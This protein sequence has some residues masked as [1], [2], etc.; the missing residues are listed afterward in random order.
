MKKKDKKRGILWSLRVLSSAKLWERVHRNITWL[1]LKKKKSF[2][3]FDRSQTSHEYW[4]YLACHILT[5]QNKN[6]S[7]RHILTSHRVQK[8][9]WALFPHKVV[10]V[11]IWPACREAWSLK[12]DLV[13]GCLLFS[14]FF[15]FLL[16]FK[17]FLQ[18]F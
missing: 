4:I 13:L 7:W 14:Y 16:K 6:I 15:N 3:Y 18:V 12:Q 5:S 10:I 8:L 1:L 9:F 17:D 2:Q 11:F